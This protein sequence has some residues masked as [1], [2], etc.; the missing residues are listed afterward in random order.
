MTARE[1]QDGELRVVVAEPRWLRRRE[2]VRRLRAVSG[3]SVVGAERDFASAFAVTLAL[4][5]HALILGEDLLDEPVLAALVHWRRRRGVRLILAARDA[6]V[7]AETLEDMRGDGAIPFDAG[8]DV[9]V[10]ALGGSPS[11]TPVRPRLSARE[12]AVVCG[13]VEGRSLKQ[14]AAD[15][16]CS[17]RTVSTYRRRAMQKLGARTPARLA[18]RMRALRLTDRGGW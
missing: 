5:P 11:R 6:R 15:L 10:R 9:L 7:A 4:R 8:P 2:I 3:L 1:E 17:L 16:A 14:I 13:T 18:A 12:Q